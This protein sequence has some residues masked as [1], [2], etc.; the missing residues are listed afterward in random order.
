M[1]RGSWLAPCL[2]RPLSQYAKAILLPWKGF[3]SGE[4]NASGRL[5]FRKKVRKKVV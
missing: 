3:D 2:E 4:R 1:K 5:K